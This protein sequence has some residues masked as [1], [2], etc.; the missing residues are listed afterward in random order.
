MKKLLQAAVLLPLLL[1]LGAPFSLAF[2]QG[3]A[4]TYQGLLNSGSNP[5]NGTYDFVSRSMGRQ[6]GQMTGSP[7]KP[8]PRRPSATVCS[9]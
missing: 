7:T 3:T 1:S 8:I 9:R 6:P 5:A 4:F 2:A